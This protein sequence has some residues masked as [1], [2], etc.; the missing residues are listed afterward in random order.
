MTCLVGT[1]DGLQGDGDGHGQ[2]VP[3]C[4]GQFCSSVPLSASARGGDSSDTKG[5]ADSAIKLLLQMQAEMRWKC[6]S[7]LSE[8]PHNLP[9]L[10][11]FGEHVTTIYQS[12]YVSFNLDLLLLRYMGE[13]AT[14]LSSSQTLR[15]SAPTL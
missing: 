14:K 10:R 5:D 3:D 4:V 7:N 13:H 12:I 8:Y 11:C 15:H 6:I 1:C 2:G 9:L